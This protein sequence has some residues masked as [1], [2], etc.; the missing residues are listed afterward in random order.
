MQIPGLLVSS[1]RIAL[2]SPWA[3]VLVLI[4]GGAGFVGANLARHLVAQGARVRVLDALLEH[5]GASLHNLDGVRDQ[6]EFQQGDVRD[7]AL[8]GRLLDGVDHVFNLVGLSGHRQSTADPLADLNANAAAPLAVLDA[9]YRL[10]P[11]ATVVYASSRQIYGRPRA[12]PIDESHPIAPIDL[13]AVHTATAESQHRIYAE[14][15]GLNTRVLRLT[16]TIGP[17]MRIRD[18]RQSFVGLWI[19]RLIEGQPFEVWGGSQRRDF[20]SVRDVA[21]ALVAL[22]LAPVDR[23]RV[24]NISGEVLSLRALADRLIAVAGGGR[25]EV[26]EMPH[27]QRLIDLGDSF[28]DATRLHAFVPMAPAQRLDFTLEQTLHFYREHAARYV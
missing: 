22:A 11:D 4:A 25:Y 10:R 13:N 15:L 1:E 26:I 8:I 16:H 7:R 2:M 12:L 21:Q 3:G 19:R 27:E 20:S 9:V 14:T 17:H 6:L 5:S 18:A 23:R 28:A 24:F